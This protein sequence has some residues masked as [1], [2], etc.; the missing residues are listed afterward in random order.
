MCEEW[1]RM[2]CST[3]FGMVLRRVGH[4]SQTLLLYPFT[5]C[6]PMLPTQGSTSELFFWCI[7]FWSLFVAA[8]WHGWCVVEDLVWSCDQNPLI[9]F[10]DKLVNQYVDGI[11][12]YSIF[13]LENVRWQ[14]SFKAFF[15]EVMIRLLVG[16]GYQPY[17][18]WVMTSCK[19]KSCKSFPERYWA[20]VKP[21]SYK[22][23]IPRTMIDS[24][25][26][27][28][29]RLSSTHNVNHF[30]TCP[31]GQRTEVVHH[32]LFPKRESSETW[33]SMALSLGKICFWEA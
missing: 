25:K 4:L 28:L 16:D 11:S 32:Y 17:L 13:I 15:W 21:F 18:G 5:G 1:F 24:S 6:S 26:R 23:V 20:M 9:H 30:D 31:K 10:D 3:C 7:D 12:P 8:V 27:F 33:K 22:L 2:V 29:W 19:F 14:W